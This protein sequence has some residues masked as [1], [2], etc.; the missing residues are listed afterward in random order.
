[1]ARNSKVLK[2]K[3]KPADSK[4][5]A[6]RGRPK[7]CM[8]CAEHVEWVDYKDL[9]VLRRFVNDRGRIKTR[10]A[11]GAC[12][13]HQRDIA[14]AIKTARELVLLPYVIRTQSPDKGERRGGPRGPRP[15][16]PSSTP[17]ADATDGAADDV[18]DDAVGEEL[19]EAVAAP[20]SELESEETTAPDLV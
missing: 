10:G 15:S 2:K 9:S 18:T 1:M 3:P 6:R 17:A 12:A 8:F 11:T 19:A 5:R 7:V 13:Q 20:D 16:E 14:V 4:A